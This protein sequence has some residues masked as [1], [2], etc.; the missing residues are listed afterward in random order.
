M[1]SDVEI[2]QS[3]IRQQRENVRVWEEGL[4]REKEKLRLMKRA[5]TSVMQE[6]QSGALDDD[7]AK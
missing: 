4:D 3:Q 6:Q 5:L 1:M 7:G 2:L